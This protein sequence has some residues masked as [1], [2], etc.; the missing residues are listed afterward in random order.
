MK[1]LSAFIFS[2]IILISTGCEEKIGVPTI[3]IQGPAN[4]TVINKGDDVTFFVDLDDFTDV[5]EVQYY[6]DN[7]LIGKTNTRPYTFKWN[8]TN[9]NTGNRKL[10]VFAYD[11]DNEAWSDE[12]IL[13]IVSI[14]EVWAEFTSD[15]TEIVEGE[16]VEFYDSSS[17]NPTHYDWNFGDGSDS[18][19]RNPQHAYNDPGTYTVTLSVL[20]DLYSDKM[21]KKNYI[22][23]KEKEC[24]PIA[25]FRVAK[26]KILTGT[27]V[28]FIDCS[29]GVP[30]SWFWDFGD[31]SFSTE[32][33]PLHTFESPGRYNVLLKVSNSVGS[34]VFVLTMVVSNPKVEYKESITVPFELIGGW[35]LI[36][37][38]C[39]MDT[40]GNDYV[41]AQIKVTIEQSLNKVSLKVFYSCRETGGDHTTFSGTRSVPL[42]SVPAGAQIVS[43]RAPSRSTIWNPYTYGKH[44]EWIP[45]SVSNS[46]CNYLYYRIDGS[47]GDCNTIGVKGEVSL[48][49]VYEM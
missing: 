41:P 1:T 44:H 32:K 29:T 8:T 37:G 42:Y 30:N 26:T 23:V 45:L 21:T 38:D 7:E 2:M 43:I 35:P 25:S 11:H 10:K 14:S 46:C 34:D 24:S 20:N 19:L 28:S 9:A 31:G 17:G 3:K 27:S 4:N 47:G 22:T 13:T 12:V 16:T 33:N 49:I 15:L 6:L 18:H 36:S 40:D 39:D 5:I 48:T